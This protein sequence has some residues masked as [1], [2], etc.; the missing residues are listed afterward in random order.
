M[1]YII[2]VGKELNAMHTSKNGY[3]L[4]NRNNVYKAKTKKQAEAVADFVAT[5]AGNKGHLQRSAIRSSIHAIK[6]EGY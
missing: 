6:W 5:H 1:A 4:D 2:K 3:V